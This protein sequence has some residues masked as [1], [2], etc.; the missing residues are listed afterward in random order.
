MGNAPQ[1]VQAQAHAISGSNEADG[2]AEA[3]E[4]FVLPTLV[5]AD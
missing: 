3:I 5:R 4:R 2:W 1:D